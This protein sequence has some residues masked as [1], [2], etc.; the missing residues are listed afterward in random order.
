[1][2]VTNREHYFNFNLNDDSMVIWIITP[3]YGDVFCLKTETMGNCDRIL[4]MDE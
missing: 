2:R 4:S 1:M 3:N